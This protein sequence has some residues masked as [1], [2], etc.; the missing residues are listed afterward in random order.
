[1]RVVPRVHEALVR[2]VAV[3]V[4]DEE[5]LA[6]ASPGD[7]QLLSKAG[8]KLLEQQIFGAPMVTYFLISQEVPTQSC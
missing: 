3:G 8:L 5:T 7:S 6:T 4:G 1:M 2:L